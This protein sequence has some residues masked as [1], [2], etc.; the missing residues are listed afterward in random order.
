ME[1][2]IVQIIQ[3]VLL[4]MSFFLGGLVL[5]IIGLRLPGDWVLIVIPGIMLVVLGCLCIGVITGLLK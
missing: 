5:I 2:N 4:I 1:K 3:G